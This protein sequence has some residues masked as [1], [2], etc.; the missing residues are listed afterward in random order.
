M[1]FRV[2]DEHKVGCAHCYGMGCLVCNGR[3]WIES[4]EGLAERQ[5]AEE[6][7]ADAER[8]RRQEK[9]DDE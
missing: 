9:E 7:W 2:K 6:D 4:A 8:E 1:R 3:G 5:Q